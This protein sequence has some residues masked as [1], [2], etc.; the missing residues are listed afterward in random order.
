MTREQVDWLNTYH[1][2]VYRTLA[3]SLGR[4]EKA[5]LKKATRPL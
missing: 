4:D 1:R 2:R 3:P 5:W